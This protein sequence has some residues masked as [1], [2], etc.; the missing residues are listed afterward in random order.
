[1]KNLVR[2][3]NNRPTLSVITPVYNGADFVERCYENLL[4]QSF[5]NWEW[6]IVDDGSTDGTAQIVQGIKD[7]RVRLFSYKQKICKHFFLFLISRE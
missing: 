2:N 1:M 3:M 5:T 7:P 4:K 6:V